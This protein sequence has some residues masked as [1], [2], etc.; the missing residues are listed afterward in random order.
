M[1]EELTPHEKFLRR[2]EGLALASLP[3]S[4]LPLAAAAPEHHDGVMVALVPDDPDQLT[5]AGEDALPADDLHVTLTFHGKIQDLSDDDQS[6]ILAKTRS[7]CDSI[8]RSFTTSTDGVVVMGKNDDGVPATALLIQ[9]DEIV[10]LYEALAEALDYESDYPT[11]IP[12]MTTGYGVPVEDAEAHVDQK[13]S[14]SKVVVKFGEDVHTIPLTSALTAAPRSANVIDRVI[15]SLGRLWDEALHP[16]DAEG[17]F[18]KKNGAVTGKLSVPSTDRKSVTQVDANRA[19]VVGFHTFDDEVWVLAEIKNPDGS[20]TQGFARATDVRAVAPVKARLDALY[21]VGEERGDAFLNA[22]GE[23]KR[24]LDL[25]AGYINAEYGDDDSDERAQ[26]FL[27]TLGLWEKDLDYLFDGSDME[28]LGGLRRPDA[29]LTD[30]E[31]DEAEDIIE[32]AQTV[33]TLRDRVHGLKEDVEGFSAPDAHEPPA[34]RLLEGAPPDPEAVAALASG[35]DP[36]EVPTDNLLGAMEASGRFTKVSPTSETGVSPIEWHVDPSDPTG[37]TV[38]LAGTDRTTTDRAYFVKSSVI[39][40]ELGQ[41]DI[42]NEVLA[43][44]ITEQVREAN[45]DD[46]RALAVPKSRFGDNPEWDGETPNDKLDLDDLGA[47]HQ[48]AHV[49]SEHT[50]YGIPEGW[51]TTDTAAEEVRLRNDIRAMDEDGQADATA[52][53]YED[54]GDVYGQDIAKMILW[55]FVTLNG[56]RNPGNAVLAIPPGGPGQEGT[57]APIDHGY[58]FD[59]PWPQDLDANLPGVEGTFE[60][61]MQY[62]ITRAWMNYLLGGLELNNNMSETRLRAIIADFTD[63]YGRIDPSKIINVFKSLPGVTDD[64]IQQVEQKLAGAV[65]RIR[66]ISDNMDTV[67]RKMT[68]RAA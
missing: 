24:Q 31:M 66:F 60:W 18:I 43:S 41:T 34:Q 22:V 42:V 62:E 11:F 32:D 13:I 6:N 2:I 9:S 64:Q 15:D 17:K 16:R 7:V 3:I 37:T 45:G 55:D 67:L 33:K 61:F 53:F 51:I 35:A 25:L 52:A 30:D 21:P 4:E 19:S 48:P 58:A 29:P 40:A 14:F 56:D 36:L 49:I 68:E 27:G 46:G 28:Y 39:G 1:A 54:M 44:L 63:T 38:R 10:E 26:E 8:G 47:S 5:V 20:S 57:I 12:H 65:D 50:G 59:E 23:R